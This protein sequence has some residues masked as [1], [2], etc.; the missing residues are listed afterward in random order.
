MLAL[1]SSTVLQLAVAV[2]V[3]VH[4]GSRVSPAMI[5]NALAETGRIFAGGGIELRWRLA[6]A[7]GVPDAMVTVVV[8]P[9]PERA[10]VSG[11]RRNL[12]DHRLG[13]TH[14][15]VRLVTLWT[16]QVAR[17]VHGDWDLAEAPGA[18]EV[19]Q[20]TLALALGRVLAHELG[21]LFLRME[22]HLDGGLMRA[23]FSHRALTGKSDRPF[24]LSSED[25]ARVRL[26]VEMSSASQH[27]DQSK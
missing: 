4:L 7:E 14:L 2:E 19:D 18:D 26:A 13:Q 1:V 27:R 25:M 16:E 8:L 3:D 6:P 17:A 24:R 20:D 23:S 9:R 5:E 15:G 21:H 11:C 12:H 10:V 22:G